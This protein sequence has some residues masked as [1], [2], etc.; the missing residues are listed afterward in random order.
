MAKKRPPIDSD[1]LFESIAMVRDAERNIV[2]EAV[3]YLD[4]YICPNDNERIIDIKHSY[5]D[6]I[7]GFRFHSRDHAAEFQQGNDFME[8]IGTPDNELS[9]CCGDVVINGRCAGCR[10]NV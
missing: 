4:M 9:K 6:P 3:S 5:L 7:S 1:A 2:T 8:Y 10:E